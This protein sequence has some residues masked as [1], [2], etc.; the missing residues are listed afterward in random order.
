[1]LFPLLMGSNPL[2]RVILVY[3]LADVLDTY[4]H[5]LLYTSSHTDSHSCLQNRYDLK[6]KDILD[7]YIPKDKTGASH[8][9]VQENLKEKRESEQ[10]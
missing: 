7:Q 4:F 6:S 10:K 3:T 8:S 9:V 5:P 2:L 1:M